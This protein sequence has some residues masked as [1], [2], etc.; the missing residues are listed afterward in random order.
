MGSKGCSLLF[1]KAAIAEACAAAVAPGCEFIISLIVLG[2]SLAF[3][4]SFG[5]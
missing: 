1:K 3:T 5:I 4:P 2:F